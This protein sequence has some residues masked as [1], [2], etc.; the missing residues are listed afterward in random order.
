MNEAITIPGARAKAFN[1]KRGEQIRI[2][3]LHG[4]QVVDAWAFCV[5]ETDEFMSNEH[6]KSSIEKVYPGLGD[7]AYTNHRRP[8]VTLID[9]NSP[10]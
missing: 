10:G 1:L 8:I 5:A 7:S 3:N 9:D 2:V 6:T 4:L